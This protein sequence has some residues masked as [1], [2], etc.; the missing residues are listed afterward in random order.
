MLSTKKTVNELINI[1]ELSDEFM[2]NYYEEVRDIN[3][4]GNEAW[5]GTMKKNIV[6]GRYFF[7]GMWMIGNGR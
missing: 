5:N 7:F 4:S 6:T 3:K 1:N 2:D